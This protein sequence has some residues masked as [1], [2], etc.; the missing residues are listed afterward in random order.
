MAR[1]RWIALSAALPLLAIAA[2]GGGGGASAS[3]NGLT[4]VRMVPDWIAPDVT[5][6]PYVVGMDKGFYK[7]AGIQQT[8]VR[9]PDNSTTVKMVA[10]GGGDIGEST[11]SDVV[12]AGEQGLPVLSIANYSQSNNWGLFGPAGKSFT[13][14]DLRGKRIGVFSDAWTKAMLPLVLRSAGLGMNDVKQVTAADGDIPLLLANK[15]DYATN[16]S[17]Y[18]IPQYQQSAGKAPSELLAK[19]HGA[20]DSPVWNYVANKS[21]LQKNPTVAKKWLSATQKATQWAISN[22]TEAV[23]MYEAH[24]KIKS[25][26]Y[27]TDLGE[28]KATTP[29][30]APKSNY[31]TATDAQWTDLAKAFKDTG[32][33][34]KALP[35]GDY[36]TND[37]ITP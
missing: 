21:W 19:D 2:C 30:I 11:S 29:F 4:T 12:F 7:D 8:I 3:A 32:Q 17:N 35:A 22:P 28:W 6:I 5:W 23:K 13:V 26:N 34:K 1:P 20:P 15:I 31:F 18:A 33:I 36:Y 14:A 10:T 37:Y 24:F 9:P 25:S 16:T 27:A